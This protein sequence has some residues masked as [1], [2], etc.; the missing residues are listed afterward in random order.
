MRAVGSQIFGHD[1][2]CEG[3]SSGSN[4]GPRSTN[5]RPRAHLLPWLGS[6]EA[7]RRGRHGHRLEG[8]QARPI[9]HQTPIRFFLRDLGYERNLFFPLT[10]VEPG[11]KMRSMGRQLE[12]QLAVVRSSSVEAPTSRST[13]TSS[14]WP[15]L[16]SRP[17]QWLQSAMNSSNLMAP[18]VRQVLGLASGNL[19]N[20]DHY[21]KN[22]YTFLV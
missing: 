14:S 10:S 20:T 8:A 15:S 18:R 16:A 1:L 4:L 2:K 5:G 3:V 17:V 22:S 6:A 19:T 11:Q 21:D 13:P 7:E 9:G 12:H